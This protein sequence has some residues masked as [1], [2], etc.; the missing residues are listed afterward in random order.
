MTAQVLAVCRKATRGISKCTEP[1]IVLLEGLGVEGDVHS[2]PTVR[3]RSRMAKDPTQPNLRQVH[4]L[5]CELFDELAAKGLEIKPGQMGENITTRGISL[6]ELPRGARLRIGPQ[7]IVELTG[8]RNPC[9]QLDGLYS[10]LMAAVLERSQQGALIRK[11]GVMGIVILGGT[12]TPGDP[13]EVEL[14]STME[15][16]EPV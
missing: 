14:P 11:A 3:H 10:G 4:V 2:G 8:L 12:V 7:A 1:R 15:P 9:A 16:L 5:H 6:L 13:I